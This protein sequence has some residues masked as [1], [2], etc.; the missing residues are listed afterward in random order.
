MI[1]SKKR[2]PSQHP[3]LFLN[4][5]CLTEVPSH[6]HLGLTFSSDLSWDTH[7]HNAIGKVIPKLNIMR[8]LKFR[9]DRFSLQQIYFSFIRPVL[10]YADIVW[11]SLPLRLIRRLENIN[12][13]AARIVTGATK[14]VSHQ[15]LYLDTKWDSLDDRRRKHRLILF[16]KIVH[17]KTPSYLREL[18]PPQHHQ[19]HNY[20]TRNRS[21]FEQ[22]HA[23]TNLYRNSFF[24]DTV[25][26]WNN[27]PQNVREDNSVSNLKLYLFKDNKQHPY[28]N[29]GTRKGQI[30]HSRLRMN[31]SSLNSTLFHKNISDSPFCS[32]GSIETARHYLLHCSNFANIRT[33][34]L[35]QLSQTYDFKTL[36]Y[37]DPSLTHDENTLIFE[38]VQ[39]YILESKRFD[40]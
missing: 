6:R 38:T 40:S 27:L 15:N 10:E 36:L 35:N 23:R 39:E 26:K 33:R 32:C 22:I 30:L 20:S 14:L 25:K 9:L 31:C 29:T 2:A 13:E 8:K 28:F 16:H 21:D 19:I 12:L 18:L 11:D 7:I 17:G 1:F 34:T 37:G 4:D 24:P 5:T 3:S